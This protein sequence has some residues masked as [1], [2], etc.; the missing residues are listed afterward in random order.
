MAGVGNQALTWPGLSRSAGS[1]LF[2][3]Q[4]SLK[5]VGLWAARKQWPDGR[6]VPAREMVLRSDGGRITLG[7]KSTQR[8][9]LLPALPR[10]VGCRL[11]VI[12][13]RKLDMAAKHLTG[14]TG[15]PRAPFSLRF[16]DHVA[17][18]GWTLLGLGVLLGGSAELRRAVLERKWREVEG[19][20][21][22]AQLLFL[23]MEQ[24]GRKALWEPATS[25]EA[26]AD[27]A[28]VMEQW[29]R[30]WSTA[31]G[32]LAQEATLNEPLHRAGALGAEWHAALVRLR[33]THPLHRAEAL[34]RYREFHAAA[35]E[36]AQE[37]LW[38][39]AGLWRTTREHWDRKLHGLRRMA[40]GGL[41]LCLV[42]GMVLWKAGHQRGHRWGEVVGSRLQA[43]EKGD[44]TSPWPVD[45]SPAW[46]TTGFVL[47]RW[48][49]RVK[50]SLEEAGRAGVV[51]LE[52]Q[53]EW[54]QWLRRMEAQEVIH[55]QTSAECRAALETLRNR[56][57]CTLTPNGSV[58][59]GAARNERVG[60]AKERSGGVS[61][62]CWS[63]TL[64]SARAQL[65]G[66]PGLLESVQRALGHVLKAADHSHLLSV[67][68][69]IEAEKAGEYG[70][71][72]AVVASELRRLA[73]QTAV[74]AGQIEEA[75]DQLR[76]Q[77]GALLQ[78]WETLER[79]LHGL[80]EP[81]RLERPDAQGNPTG[82]GSCPGIFADEGFE[83][84]QE[85][86]H[87]CLLMNRLSA[88]GA[89]SG[90]RLEEAAHLVARL[91]RLGE[92]LVACTN[93]YGLVPDW[94]GERLGETPD[95]EMPPKQ[96][97]PAREGAQPSAQPTT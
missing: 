17:F 52:L 10:G 28:L 15:R 4:G 68:A 42:G 30:E 71:G 39:W 8:V 74:A 90:V 96:G 69:A 36:R 38:A 35:V 49:A 76:S 14:E 16:M 29:T 5:R 27:L 64:E 56:A 34:Q 21:R 13:V 72:F 51:L 32:D 82:T 86:E 84:R 37:W 63:R 12:A 48:I 31:A 2:S 75:M 73:D 40:W 83:L 60:P 55:R 45:H 85:I 53:R 20:G 61:E 6:R 66:V 92:R 22:Q 3:D 11:L 18:A 94:Q 46:R 57:R 7:N 50:T 33:E 93:S 81:G 1:S 19:L 88:A 58:E 9:A 62:P 23:S 41:G 67:N 87:C 80:T 89:E 97:H 26:S 59:Q 91:Q 79:D 44:W 78:V 65:A 77:V 24:A 47:A 70:L 43:L 25:L 54:S 95:Q